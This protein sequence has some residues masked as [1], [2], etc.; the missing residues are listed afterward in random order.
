MKKV[1]LAGVAAPALLVATAASAQEAPPVPTIGGNL[2]LSI[3]GNA[4]FSVIGGDDDRDRTDRSRGYVFKSD[5]S[6]VRFNAKATADNGIGYG[7]SVEIQTQTNDESNADETWVFLDSDGFGRVELGDQDG[8]ADRMFVDAADVMKGRGGFDGPTGDYV[9]FGSGVSGPS[10]GQTSDATKAIYFTPRF[11]GFQ[12]GG[13]FTPDTGH[14]GSAGEVDNDGTFKNVVSLGAN[15]QQSFEDVSVT[16][17]AGGQFGEA[18]PPGAG[19]T[20]G[21]D[22]EVWGVGANVSFAGFTVGAGY[23]DL[24]ETGEPALTTGDAGSW[25]DLAASYTSGPWGVAVGTFNSERDIGA[26][27][28]EVSIYSLTGSYTVAP[29]LALAADINFIDVDNLN[30]AGDDNDG[31]SWVISL[32]AS[33]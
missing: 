23:T 13:S 9:D 1:L 20:P 17:A 10:F 25:W 29:G 4:R 5:E 12:A 19:V 2:D 14:S 7:L 18:E 33:F 27:D 3:S 28:T 30:T 24:N 6:E 16:V 26:V 31:V 22:L 8:A 32:T 21:Q 11:S 15:Y